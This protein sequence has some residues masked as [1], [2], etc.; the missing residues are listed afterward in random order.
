MNFLI[1]YKIDQKDGE[2]S[3]TPSLSQRKMIASLA[4]A[5]TDEEY[6]E[7]C[8]QL[9]GTKEEFDKI[10]G[11]CDK[12]QSEKK[13]FAVQSALYRGIFWQILSEMDKAKERKIKF[14]E[15]EAEWLEE[16]D[17]Y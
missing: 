11:E 12:P 3:Q 10:D 14:E 13:Y 9:Y 7:I 1:Y 8:H 5:L 2:V 16:P 4:E 15:A 17:N 6:H